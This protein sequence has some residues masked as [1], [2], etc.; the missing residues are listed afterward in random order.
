MGNN[1]KINE[2]RGRRTYRG[3]SSRISASVQQRL[4]AFPLKG[5]SKTPDVTAFNT[6]L[7]EDEFG[8]EKFE[9]EVQRLINERKGNK[10]K[11]KRA[12]VEDV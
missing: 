9:L 8:G 10:K 11:R 1:R 3:S 6:K 5:N 4:D 2:R 12:V 7:K